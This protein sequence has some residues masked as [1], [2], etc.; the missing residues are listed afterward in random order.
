MLWLW[1]HGW[2]C[3]KN[4]LRVLPNMK[5]NI[6]VVTLKVADMSQATSV[7][8]N[9]SAVAP[10]DPDDGLLSFSKYNQNGLKKRRR[11]LPQAVS[12]H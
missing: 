7:S 5:K 4:K 9:I 2:T 12:R 11:E 10:C 3:Y 6:A 1:S 8:F